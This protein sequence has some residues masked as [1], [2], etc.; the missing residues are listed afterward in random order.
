MDIR[1]WEE[2][3]LNL[4]LIISVINFINKHN[5]RHELVFSKDCIQVL[6]VKMVNTKV[7][8]HHKVRM[9]TCLKV[10]SEKH[11]ECWF[12]F[13]KHDFR[14]DH[15]AVYKTTCC[16]TFRKIVSASWL[17]WLFLLIVLVGF[18]NLCILIAT[19]Y[20]AWFWSWSHALPIWFCFQPGFSVLIFSNLVGRS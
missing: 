18:G 17:R 16:L 2:K 15:E 3:L 13:S 12:Y 19:V 8:K 7:Q 11:T 5:S 14:L 6:S 4:V 10:E 1:N 20:L 9:M